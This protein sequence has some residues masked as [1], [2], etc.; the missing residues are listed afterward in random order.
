MK[1]LTKEQKQIVDRYKVIT[2]C[3]ESYQDSVFYVPNSQRDKDY[4]HQ[5]TYYAE[6]FKKLTGVSI[7]EYTWKVGA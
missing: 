5:L 7:D 6:S 3:Q 4:E 2:Q 1:R